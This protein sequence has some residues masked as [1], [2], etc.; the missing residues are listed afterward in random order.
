MEKPSF[1][2]GFMRPFVWVLSREPSCPPTLLDR[3]KLLAS[4]QRV[5]LEDSHALTEEWVRHSGDIYFGLRTG[6]FFCLGMGGALDYAINSAASV[7]QGVAIANRYARLF[8]DLMTA[9]LDSNGNRA[10][11]RLANR[12]A[13]PRVVA[14]FTMSA[15]YLNHI[16]L[17][18][19]QAEDLECWFAQ[20][21]PPNLAEYERVFAPAK[22][23]FN[24]PCYGFSFDTDYAEKPLPGTDPALHAAHCERVQAQHAALFGTRTITVRVR[25]LLTE[26]F[27]NSRP[28]AREIARRLHMSRRTLARRLETE[29][30]TFGA[31]VDDLRQRLAKQYM[32]R[33]E[34]ELSE[35]AELLGF[36]HLQAFHRAFK[37]WTGQTP[38]HFR[39]H[40]QAISALG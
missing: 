9:E 40:G 5:A 6:Q 34:L 29:G 37:R 27:P 23:R 11:V 36:S 25:D 8:G 14:D 39:E 35:I 32:A 20:P 26:Q 16:R 1:A 2:P 31:Q 15:W 22:L 19:Y 24:A 17:Q 38:G 7:S 3:Y 33:P 28:T 4:S 30:T 10:L 21:P 12:M 18:L 13:W